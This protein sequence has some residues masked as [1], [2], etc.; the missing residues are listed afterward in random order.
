MIAVYISITAIIAGLATLPLPDYTNRD[1]SEE[2]H[3]EVGGI[4]AEATVD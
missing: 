2:E 3:Y 1:V 4:T